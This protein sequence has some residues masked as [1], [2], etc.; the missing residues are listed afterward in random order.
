MTFVNR[1]K[2][3]EPFQAMR[4]EPALVLVEMG[5][6]HFPAAASFCDIA[7]GLGQLESGQPLTNDF[8]LGG[9]HEILLSGLGKLRFGYAYASFHSLIIN[10]KSSFGKKISYSYCVSWLIFKVVWIL[11]KY[12]I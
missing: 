6:G 11:I 3:L 2:I 12:L 5:T 1:R 9:G 8:L 4:L 10:D 7:Q